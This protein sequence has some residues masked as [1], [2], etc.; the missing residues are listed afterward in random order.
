MDHEPC[1]VFVVAR[2]IVL[3]GNELDKVVLKVMPALKVEEQVLVLKFQG[4]A[5]GETLGWLVW[6][7]VWLLISAQAVISGF[8]D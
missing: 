8:W 2:L 4:A 7:S 3:P 6:L 1:H 5:G